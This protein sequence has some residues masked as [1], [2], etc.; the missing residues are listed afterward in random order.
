MKVF[1][2]FVCVLA[3]MTTGCSSLTKNLLKDPDVQ[4]ENVEV[5]DISLKDISLNLKFNV[6]N[7][8]PIPIHLSQLNYSI[9]LSG[10]KVT[11]G[12]FDKSVNIPASGAGQIVVPLKFEYNAVGSL[13]DGLIK[14]T[15]TRD[16][17]ITGSAKLGIFSIPFSKKGQIE[18]NKK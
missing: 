2:S 7:P 3:F 9:H 18:L 10:Q 4:L 14:K 16:Y 6:Q 8:N 13:L 12:L 11:E 17:E 15:L 5:A 1:L